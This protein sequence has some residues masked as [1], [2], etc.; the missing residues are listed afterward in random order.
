[1]WGTLPRRSQKRGNAH[2]FLEGVRVR[3]GGGA[4]HDASP[5]SGT[6]VERLCEIPVRDPGSALSVL[7]KASRK[8]QAPAGGEQGRACTQ[9]TAQ[10]VAALYVMPRYC[11]MSQGFLAK[12]PPFSSLAVR[13]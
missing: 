6:S 9:V 7:E 11:R 5:F 4:A 2:I 13:P 10:D 3:P 8:K 12:L 1:M